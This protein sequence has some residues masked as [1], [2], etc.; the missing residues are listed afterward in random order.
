MK[1]LALLCLPIALALTMALRL[2][3]P[4]P[5]NAPTWTVTFTP[6]PSPTR[7]VMT[8][9]PTKPSKPSKATPTPTPRLAPPSKSTRTP[10]PEKRVYRCWLPWVSISG[11]PV[12]VVGLPPL[13][14]CERDRQAG[15][16]MPTLAAPPTEPPPTAYP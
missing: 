2:P 6:G 13:P 16:A 4:E 5:Q 15:C 11:A 1:P 10:V 8:A 14:V 7:A 9:L 3:V 12:V